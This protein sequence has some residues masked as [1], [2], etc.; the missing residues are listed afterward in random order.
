MHVLYTLLYLLNHVPFVSITIPLII[1]ISEGWYFVVQ[2]L[3]VYKFK[4]YMVFWPTNGRIVPS[5]WYLIFFCNCLI[6]TIRLPV[7][8]S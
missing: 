2:G 4:L 6:E 1:I 3:C 8:C 7:V 5:L